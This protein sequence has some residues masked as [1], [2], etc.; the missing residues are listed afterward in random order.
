[1]ALLCAEFLVLGRDSDST[2]EGGLFEQSDLYR[3]RGPTI[4]KVKVGL[5]FRHAAI[6]R[7]VDRA[8]EAETFGACP[9][10]D[11]WLAAPPLARAIEPPP[12]PGLQSVIATFDSQFAR[13]RQPP[14]QLPPAPPAP[15][16]PEIDFSAVIR[17][18]LTHGPFP[19][20]P[21]DGAPVEDQQEADDD[22]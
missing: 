13:L 1:M 17:N 6:A 3:G 15:A 7:L 21:A 20:L 16:L 12:D 5:A 18:L 10:P 9:S 2:H 19:A 22:V 11:E 4:R 8:F 14:A